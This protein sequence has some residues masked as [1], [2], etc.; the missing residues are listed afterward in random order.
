MDEAAEVSPVY[1]GGYGGRSGHKVHLRL[2]GDKQL[3][4]IFYFTSLLHHCTIETIGTMLA[5]AVLRSPRWRRGTSLPRARYLHGL[6][7]SPQ[8]RF[9]NV[10]EEVRDAVATGKPVV[11]L[12]TT[13]YTHGMFGSTTQS[14]GNDFAKRGRD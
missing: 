10:S 5:R 14:L 12:E 2:I 11:A 4:L 7:D 13:I 1:K 6:K 8:S 3:L 9:L